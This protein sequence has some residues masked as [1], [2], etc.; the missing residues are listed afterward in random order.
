MRST[1]TDF[2]RRHRLAGVLVALVLSAVAVTVASPA[3]A[4]PQA[5]AALQASIDAQLRLAPGGTQISRNQVAWNGDSVI[6]TF[7]EPASTPSKV[8]LA[9]RCPGGGWACFFEDRDW[10][11]RMLQFRSCGY[12]QWFS[13]YGFENQTSSWHNRQAFRSVNVFD[14]AEG[15]LWF[16]EQGNVSSSYVGDRRNDKAD[17]F[18]INC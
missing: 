12:I 3:A 16:M 6:M 14:V 17:Y 9:P 11:G 5:D 2:R 15:E 1:S 13:D 18:R 8:A 10:G 7:P 4:S